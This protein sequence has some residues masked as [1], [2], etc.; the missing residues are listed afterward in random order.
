MADG[1]WTE[2]R[3]RY[4]KDGI[5]QTVPWERDRDAAVSEMARMRERGFVTTLLARDVTVTGWRVE[6]PDA[7]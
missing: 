5:V 3:V 7:D 6:V 1:H 4:E 2:Y